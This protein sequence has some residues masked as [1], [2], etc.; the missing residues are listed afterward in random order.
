[1]ATRNETT[2]YDDIYGLFITNCS[3]DPSALPNTPEKQYDVIKNAILLFNNRMRDN[4]TCDDD[5][6][7]VSRRLSDD[8]QLIIARYIRLTLLRNLR[9]YKNS[10][11]TVFTKEI[12]VR[13]IN[14]QLN[15]L[16]DEIEQEE[17]TIDMLIFHMS[18]ES[19]M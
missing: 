2:T 15:S 17:N 19:I 10:I 12:G 6:E 14:A 8:E 7:I 9:T 18:D 16:K 1:M 11:F 3:V 5:Q 13:N 4:I